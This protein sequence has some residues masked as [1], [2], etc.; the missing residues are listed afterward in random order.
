MGEKRQNQG[1]KSFEN[2]IVVLERDQTERLTN[3]GRKVKLKENKQDGVRKN[4]GLQLGLIS[5]FR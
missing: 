3:V 2:G 1:K 5:C 4:G